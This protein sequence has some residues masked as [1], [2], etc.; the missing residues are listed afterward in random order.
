MDS[1]CGNCVESVIREG[2]I[3]VFMP[4]GIGKLPSSTVLV[5][6]VDGKLADFWQSVV[7]TGSELVPLVDCSSVVFTKNLC[8]ILINIGV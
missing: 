6:S 1:L 7:E 2:S 4:I 3:V 8:W 5:I